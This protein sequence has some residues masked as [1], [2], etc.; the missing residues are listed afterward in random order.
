MSP[1]NTQNAI[2]R[3]QLIKSQLNLT[4]SSMSLEAPKDMAKERADASF[5][6][7][8]LSYL[9]LGGEEQY[10]SR[11]TKTI[12]AISQRKRCLFYFIFLAKSIRFYSA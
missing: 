2:K 7:Q 9:W 8:A 11:V 3:L 1:P 12:K 10:K 5:D 4:P 6:I